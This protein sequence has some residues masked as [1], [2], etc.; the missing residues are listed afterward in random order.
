M[1]FRSD[2]YRLLYKEYP[3]FFLWAAAKG[4]L[5]LPKHFSGNEEDFG[6]YDLT[7]KLYIFMKRLH[8]SYKTVMLMDSEER[9]RLFTMEM[10]LVEEEQKQAKENNNS[11]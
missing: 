1:T 9:D 7:S 11:R 6:N 10:K 4:I 5:F 2:E 3:M 8:Q